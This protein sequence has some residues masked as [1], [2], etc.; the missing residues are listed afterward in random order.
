[1][2]QLKQMGLAT[3]NHENSRKVFPTG[4]SHAWPDIKY[5]V[6]DGKPLGRN[7]RGSVGPSKSFPI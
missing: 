7:A 4:G 1:M 2:N 6:E 5:Y 3:L